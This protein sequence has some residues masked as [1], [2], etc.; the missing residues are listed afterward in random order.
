VLFRYDSKTLAAPWQSLGLAAADKAKQTAI[1]EKN[2]G[3]THARTS[4]RQLQQ[5]AVASNDPPPI[6]FL[7]RTWEQ[8]VV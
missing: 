4:P 3:I 5:P 6:A 8:K 1:A 7:V 2:N